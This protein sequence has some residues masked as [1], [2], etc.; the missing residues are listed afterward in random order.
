M[1]E[2]S[3][4]EDTNVREDDVKNHVGCHRTSW[5]QSSRASNMI[6]GPTEGTLKLEYR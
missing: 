2:K 4:D 1:G 5:R 6:D 3:K